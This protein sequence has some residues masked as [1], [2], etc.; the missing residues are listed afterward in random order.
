MDFAELKQKNAAELKE[1]LTQQQA[2]IYQLRQKIRGNA[3]KQHH[4]IGQTRK[5]IA[6]IISLLSNSR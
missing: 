1:I 4:L 3:L 5:T 2:H 6:R